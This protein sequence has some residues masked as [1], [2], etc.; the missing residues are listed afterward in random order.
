MCYNIPVF[1][2]KT[3]NGGQIL[4]K[5]KPALAWVLL[6]L[7]CIGAFLYNST[8]SANPG[9]LD[10][11]GWVDKNGTRYYLLPDGSRATGWQAIGGQQYYFR[12]D[13]I[14][15]TGWLELDGNHYYLRTSGS[16]V[17]DW[18]MLEDEQYYFHEDG[19]AATGLIALDGDT[20]L[21]HENGM[22]AEGWI[23]IEGIC[24]YGDR[25]G[26]PVTGWLE[27]G[28]H[29]YY[30]DE[31]FAMV[32]GWLELDGNTYYLGSDGAAATGKRTIDGE[33]HYFASK[34]QKIILVN[35]W[36]YVPE[37]YTV[38]LTDI[39]G[40]HE[41]AACAYEDFMEMMTDCE[42]AGL[43]P[44]V[45][46]SYRTQEYQQQLYDNRIKRWVK[47]GYSQE[48]ATGLAG[49]S[50]AIPGTS[51]HQL[52]LAVDIIDNAN[53]KLDESQAKMP[54]QI[55]LM[56]NSWRYGFI[57]RYPDGTSEQTGIIYEPW[58]YRYVGKEIAAEIFELDVCLEEYL[59][60]L[61]TSVG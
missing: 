35:P 55:W 59:E 47:A 38:E 33:T 45:C 29:R 49:R 12:E 46:S 16:M 1:A 24:Y 15:V 23:E 27:E 9:T 2:E 10:D 40:G 51:E 25:N 43:A 48:E 5:L 18:L 58:H 4:T 50:V 56:E 41:I 14:P 20:Y 31:N 36:N 34:G 57:L 8:A 60:N 17:T 13:G 11:S 30:F 53:W 42:A 52:G 19:T 3:R 61:T 44:V 32:T 39:G 6:A 54:T 21:F 37:D 26:H 22:L 28:G 7:I